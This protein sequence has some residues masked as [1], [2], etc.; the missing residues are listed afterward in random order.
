M[1]KFK[2]FIGLC[3]VLFSACERTDFPDLTDITYTPDLG[4]RGSWFTITA[5]VNNE[6]GDQLEYTWTC[7]EGH[8]RGGN[9]TA[10]I[11]WESSYSSTETDQVLTV[12]VTNGEK[13]VTK[14]VTV[15]IGVPTEFLFEDE[16][17]ETSYKGAIIGTQSWMIENLKYLPSVNPT[18]DESATEAH[19]YVYNYDG[20]NIEE[21]KATDNYSTN[22]VL[23]NLSAALEACP[24]GWHLPTDDDFKTLEAYLGMNES[25][26]DGTSLRISGNVGESLKS[27]TGWYSTYNG[28]NSS[29]FNALPSGRIGPIRRAFDG[30]GD[31]TFFWTA[32]PVDANKTWGRYLGSDN[33]EDVDRISLE[34]HQGAS[35][36]CVK[37]AG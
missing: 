33:T 17:D 25:D 8:I 9:G 11:E 1:K 34:N 18:I 14:S 5:N 22:G 26:L 2:V 24:N 16:R 28:T 3:I 19:Y 37:D 36:R 35:V 23:Y 15:I 13:S 32:S 20:S 4:I 31:Q 6:D 27:Q 10:Q 12:E 7:N 30:I 21:A 29:G